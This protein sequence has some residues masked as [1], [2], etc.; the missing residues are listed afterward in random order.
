MPGSAM[1]SNQLSDRP[2]VGHKKVRT[3]CV[4]CKCID[5]GRKC[6]GYLPPQK[7]RHFGIDRDET[8]PSEASEKEPLLVSRQLNSPLG[9]PA[10]K[11]YLEFYQISM[12]SKMSGYF[13]SGFWNRLILQLSHTEPCINHAITALSSMHEQFE[14]SSRSSPPYSAK[15]DELTLQSYNAAIKSLSVKLNSDAQSVTVPLVACLLFVCIEFMRRDIDAAMRHIHSGCAILRTRTESRGEQWRISRSHESADATPG[16]VIEETVMSIFQ[17]LRLLCGLFFNPVQLKHSGSAENSDGDAFLGPYFS[18]FSEARDTLMAAIAPALDLVRITGPVKYDPAP[19]AR[20]QTEQSVIIA[21]LNQW[22]GN[23]EAWYRNLELQGLTQDERT[24][25]DLLRLQ[26][27]AALIHVSTCLN[28]N[29]TAYDDYIP[30]FQEM[31]NLGASVL[32]ANANSLEHNSAFSFEM[33]TIPP[34]VL[35]AVKCR[36]P[37]IRRRALSLLI[38]RPR[39]EGLW[40]AYRAGRAAERAVIHEEQGLYLESSVELGGATREVPQ[41]TLQGEAKTTTEC[42]RLFREHISRPVA[43]QAA[44][45]ISDTTSSIPGI[46]VEGTASRVRHATPT[47]LP[48][49]ANR[50]H[51]S[52][53]AHNAPPAAESVLPVMF[54][55]K[56]HGLNGDWYVWGEVLQL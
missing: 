23:F 47:T 15:G 42:V 20:Y 4:T 25:A 31:V 46:S 38:D 55:W 6:E 24:I 19:I 11:R 32:A 48:A 10:Q 8:P 27:G 12:A 21:G 56:P 29:E 2:R 17:R 39:R 37:T 18:N 16:E 3:G 14:A 9:S 50:I 44:S 52:R 40:D 30:M 43:G 45:P 22:R 36:H 13:D 35:T 28:V 34:L 33:G 54:K 53:V 26:H 7:R 51:E 5:T 1:Q 41:L 49:E